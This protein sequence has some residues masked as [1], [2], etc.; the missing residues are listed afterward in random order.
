MPSFELETLNGTRFSS[1]ALAGKVALIDFWATWCQPC[2]E[3]IPFWNQ[4]QQRHAHQ[5]FTVLGIAVQSGWASDIRSD[6][7]KAK[8]EIKY[9]IMVGNEKVAQEFGGVL[10][11]PTTFLIDRNSQ[12]YRKYTGQ[13]PGKQAEIEQDIEKLLSQ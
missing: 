7:E 1:T 6:I 13:Y 9:P 5:G 2:I 8:L 11:F 10:G 3:E 12:I 4:L